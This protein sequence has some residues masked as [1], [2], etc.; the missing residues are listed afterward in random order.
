M[1]SVNCHL[2][3]GGA[4]GLKDRQLHPCLLCIKR[5]RSQARTKRKGRSTQEQPVAARKKLLA[6]NFYLGSQFS[7]SMSLD[8]LFFFL[9]PFTDSIACAINLGKVETCRPPRPNN[10]SHL[11]FFG[12][13]LPKWIPNRFALVPIRDVSPARLMTYKKEV[14]LPMVHLRL[15]FNDRHKTR[16]VIE[17]VL[18]QVYSLLGSPL[19][20]VNQTK[21]PG[22]TCEAVQLTGRY[23]GADIVPKC[24]HDLC[25]RWLVP[26]QNG[27]DNFEVREVTARTVLWVRANRSSRELRSLHYDLRD[28]PRWS[29]AFPFKY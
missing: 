10:G 28:W 15:L 26:Y 18:S 6:K 3:R 1:L 8:L 12:R 22:C 16:P 9:G 2:F 4:S 17:A 23:E 13:Q 21:R 20:G 5:K 11:S 25:G 19:D 29:M 24:G 27:R 14:I 7:S